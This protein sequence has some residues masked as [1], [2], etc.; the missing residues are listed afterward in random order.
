MEERRNYDTGFFI[1]LREILLWHQTMWGDN[2]RK[3]S[4]AEAER[5]EALKALEEALKALVELDEKYQYV[6]KL[7]GDTL[8]TSNELAE[9]FDELRETHRQYL[10]QGG[11]LHSN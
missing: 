11:R 7:W 9:R 6:L 5:D 8:N 3:R 10:K 1:R 2:K 4:K